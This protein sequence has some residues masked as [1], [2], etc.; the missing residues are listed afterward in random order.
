MGQTV[1]T[2]YFIIQIL[3]NYREESRYVQN[4]CSSWYSLTVTIWCLNSG[5]GLLWLRPSS[6]LDSFADIDYL[7]IHVVS[8]DVA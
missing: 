6:L 2:N 5:E 4:I 8:L 1:C 7:D 3:I